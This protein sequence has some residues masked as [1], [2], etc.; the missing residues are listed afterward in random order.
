[1]DNLCRATANDIACFLTGTVALDEMQL[2]NAVA[3]AA[4]T[5]PLFRTCS[6]WRDL[7]DILLKKLWLGHLRGLSDFDKKMEGH[8]DYLNALIKRGEAI[9]RNFERHRV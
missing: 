6:M 2:D 9:D 3:N 7:L 8:K 5:I 4:S 1:M